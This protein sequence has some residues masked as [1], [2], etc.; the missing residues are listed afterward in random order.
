MLFNIYVTHY[1][2]QRVQRLLTVSNVF[3]EVG[4]LSQAWFAIAVRQFGNGESKLY[5]AKE[6]SDDHQFG[7]R[8]FTSLNSALTSKFNQ[9]FTVLTIATGCM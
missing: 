6:T 3:T 9:N 1:C 4:C 8:L 5:L 2:V 7:E